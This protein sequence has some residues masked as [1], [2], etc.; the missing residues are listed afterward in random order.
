MK[1]VLFTIILLLCCRFISAQNQQAMQPLPFDTAVVK[2]TLPN[3][4]TYYIQHNDNP[5][6]RA[7]FYIA[8]KVGAVQEEEN[9]RGLAHFLEHMCFNGSEHFPGNAL[10]QYCQ[11]IGI[12]FGADL[13]AYTAA[14]RTVYNINNVPTTDEKNLDSCLLILYDWSHALTLDPKEIDK[15]RGVI[16]EEWRMRSSAMMRILER[17]LPTLMAGSKYGNRLPIGLMSVVDNFKPE[18]L[19]AYYEKWYRPDLQGIVII[20]DFDVKQM[21]QKVRSL[22]GKIPTPKTPSKFEYYPVPDNAQPIIVVDKDK[23][24]TTPNI[25]IAI[26]HDVLPRELRS[27]AAVV[28]MNYITTILS[29]MF[30]YRFDD[31]LQNPDAPYNALDMSDEDYILATTKKALTF[32][33]TPKDGKSEE[34]TADMLREIIRA[35][36]Y[37]FT[38]AEYERA[39]T[40]Y[41]SNW[42]QAREARKKVKTGQLVNECVNNFLDNELKTSFEMRY[43]LY[44]QMAKMIPLNIVNT[45]LQKIVG[46]LDTN[47][48]ILATYPERENVTVPEKD[49]FE[50]LLTQVKTEDIKPYEVKTVNTKLLENEPQ[51]GTIKKELPA[52]NMGY[53]T[54]V[55]SNG[56]KVL[57]KSTDFDESKIIMSA[58]SKGGTSELPLKE[59]DNAQMFNDVMGNNGLGQFNS[60]DLR[61]ALTGR[62]VSIAPQIRHYTESINGKSSPKDFRTFMQLVHLYFTQ[63]NNDTLNYRNVLKNEEQ[64]LANRAANP[65]SALQDSATIRFRD[66]NPRQQPFTLERLKNV[67]YEGI[68]KIYQERFGNAN[69]FTFI[70]TGNINADSIR[71][72]AKLY[73]ASL[74]V[75]KSKPENYKNDGLTFWKGMQQCRFN[76]KMETPMAI[77]VQA[78]NGKYPYSV[79]N[80]A[81]S[82]AAGRVLDEMYLQTVREKYSLVYSINSDV[83]LLNDPNPIFLLETACPVKPE[84]CDSA[85][86]L[87]DEGMKNIADHGVGQE[88]LSKVKEQMLKIYENNLRE[89]N[90]WQHLQE[91]KILQNGRDG[92]TGYKEALQSITSD[93]IQ[94]FIRDIVIKQQNRMNLIMLPQ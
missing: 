32:D 91:D 66:N 41:L 92:Y 94:K 34:A 7:Y 52:D 18:A 84:K 48:V 37:G 89:N 31:L 3:G 68:R 22:F 59:L 40:Q 27:T 25:E 80:D 47:V 23:E 35:V 55:L 75:Q 19:R 83:T 45:Y 5:R 24:V 21:E 17:Q 20:G 62:Q 71:T 88:Y 9:Q 54:I 61:K 13:N 58:V 38:D 10:I 85:L 87:V 51:A 12:Q 90:F 42:D 74:P 4:M 16:H 81:V 60:N 70:F 1:K 39:K 33:V 72:F 43:Q 77:M 30:S 14:D 78:W 73:L 15:E 28:P 56:I 8:Q 65:Q 67:S 53:K 29:Q 63:L 82:E 36:K 6:N 11:R 93:D 26:K 86:L 57:Y 2:G 50:K 79:K 76:K 44:K 49:V 46:K 69:D 64:E